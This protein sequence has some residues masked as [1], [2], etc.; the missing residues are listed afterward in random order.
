[1]SSK[2]PIQTAIT[3]TIGAIK[4]ALQCVL[5]A[6]ETK[7]I[8]A[9]FSAGVLMLHACA[10]Q[11][12]A[13]ALVPTEGSLPD[14]VFPLTG[15]LVLA[16]INNCDPAQECSISQQKDGLRLK[17]AGASIK[18]NRYTEKEV[19]FFNWSSKDQE[20]RIVGNFESVYFRSALRS[21]AKFHDESASRYQLRGVYFQSI[22]GRLVLAATNGMRLAEKITSIEVGDFAPMTIG[23]AYIEALVGIIKGDE[24]VECSVVGGVNPTAVIFATST[25]S[26]KCPLIGGDYPK[27]RAIIPKTDHHVTVNAAALV[28]ALE[29][30]EAV[31]ATRFVQLNFKSGSI[32]IVTIDSES[33]EKIES[34]GDVF[35]LNL[36]IQPQLL[37]GLL[38]SVTT[39]QI[40]LGVTLG[41]GRDSFVTVRNADEDGWLGLVTPAKL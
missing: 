41:N 9:E 38:S 24:F 37:A 16:I 14:M 11:G 40:K 31:S 39:E 18:L 17:F 4:L 33:N 30:M 20:T 35:T 6:V 8:T 21:V 5:K 32:D 23:G 3:T 10:N 25:F 34:D 28:A 29:R 7:Q 27:Y 12:H 13:K 26:I 2:S 36:G 15:K 19:D 22:G 1:M